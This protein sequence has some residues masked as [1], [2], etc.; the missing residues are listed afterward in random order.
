[1]S[2]TEGFIDGVLSALP[3][4]GIDEL[5]N[6]LDNDSITQKSLS[7]LLEKYEIDPLTILK[8]GKEADNIL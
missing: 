5:K 3:K 8:E 6:L 7:E 1:M 4:E 2:I